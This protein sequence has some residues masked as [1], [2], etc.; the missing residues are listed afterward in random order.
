MFFLTACD[1]HLQNGVGWAVVVGLKLRVSWRAAKTLNYTL[2]KTSTNSFFQNCRLHSVMQTTVLKSRENFVSCD[3]LHKI[4]IDASLTA[5]SF[6]S[7]TLCL[8]F[9]RST[10]KTQI[11]N[12]RLMHYCR[13]FN[14]SRK[15]R[16][17]DCIRDHPH[18]FLYF[19]G[20]VSLAQDIVSHLTVTQQ[21]AC[22]SGKAN[23]YEF[24]LAWVSDTAVNVE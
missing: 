17:Q 6:T 20:I 3:S 5:N 12:I 16:W 15:I 1:S 21:S 14:L 10:G 4:N 24:A 11:R 9:S 18:V 13:S 23:C 2:S 22:A 7:P 19:G 8:L